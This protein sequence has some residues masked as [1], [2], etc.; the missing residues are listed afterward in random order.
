VTI[1]RFNR[2]E[3]K[4]V[5]QAAKCAAIIEDLAAFTTPPNGGWIMLGK[6]PS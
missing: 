2:Y 1:K 6:H 5:L 3:L 4:Y